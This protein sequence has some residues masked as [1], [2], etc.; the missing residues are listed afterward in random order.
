MIRKLLVLLLLVLAF[1]CSAQTARPTPSASPNPPAAPSSA[2]PRPSA[3]PRKMELPTAAK[4]RQFRLKMLGQHGA[5]TWDDM[6][7]ARQCRRCGWVAAR[8]AVFPNRARPDSPEHWLKRVLEL[9]SKEMLHGPCPQCQAT[10][11]G[12]GFVTRLLPSLTFLEADGDLEMTVDL[13]PKSD[14]KV[15]LELARIDGKARSLPWPITAEAFQEQVGAP[16][17]VRALWRSMLERHARGDHPVFRRVQD[18]YFLIV[19]PFIAK[20]EELE[21]IKKETVTIL[22]NLTSQ[23]G[24]LHVEALKDL[25]DQKRPFTKD[26]Y[27]DWLPDFAL[28]IASG[29]VQ[30]IA[31]VHPPTFVATFAREARA[32]GVEATIPS[33]RAVE[34]VLTR[35]P[36]RTKVNCVAALLRM[37]HQGQSFQQGAAPLLEEVNRVVAMERVGGRIMALVR[38]KATTTVE[39]GSVLVVTIGEGKSAKVQRLS[40]ASLAFKLYA[41]TPEEVDRNIRKTIGLDPKTGTFREAKVAKGLCHCGQPVTLG[42]KLRPRRLLTEVAKKL[43]A[44]E[45]QGVVLAAVWECPD[46][47][48]Y[49][50]VGEKFRGFDEALKA[51]DQAAG[52]VAF[53]LATLGLVRVG[54][55][56]LTYVAGQDVSTVAVDEGLAR[57]LVKATFD[58]WAAHPPDGPPAP[59]PGPDKLLA[60][61]APFEHVVVLSPT[62]LD[63]AGRERLGHLVKEELKSTMGHPDPGSPLGFYRQMKL[64]KPPRG[65]FGLP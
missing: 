39:D 52:S 44:R 45:E 11:A 40:L 4:N 38:G 35:G 58:H 17:S 55:S 53:G 48:E 59:L 24:A 30:P 56:N 34:V 6:L 37:V 15:T 33:T 21:R 60:V 12:T 19:R 23:V 64:E 51:F 16:L 62:P 10:P 57:G 42:V 47:I 54:D 29:A 13:V 31:A 32:L 18:G 3:A 7:M 2:Q 20:D 46:H 25:E 43:V 63:E 27:H 65:K 61:F 49:L 50:T 41:K 28:A 1:D 5:A 22:N 26:T 9:T 36:W 14:P 8:Q